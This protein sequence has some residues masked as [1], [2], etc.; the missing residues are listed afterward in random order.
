MKLVDTQAAAVAVGRSAAT[1]RGWIHE[2]KIIKHGTER[3][4]ALVDLE[5]VYAAANAP[6]KSAAQ[7]V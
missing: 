1:I 4:R 3:R 7:T 5:E 6:R 2:G